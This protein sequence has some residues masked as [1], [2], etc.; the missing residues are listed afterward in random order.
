M[1]R[2]KIISVALELKRR[3]S[4]GSGWNKMCSQAEHIIHVLEIAYISYPKFQE[5]NK[6]NST[7]SMN[8]TSI[9]SPEHKERLN[10][11][12]LTLHINHAR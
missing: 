5:L 2:D 9:I 6:K 1:T 8:E 10:R 11:Q 4:A 12:K 7:R 3:Q